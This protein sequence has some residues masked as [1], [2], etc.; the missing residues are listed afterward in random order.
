M[1]KRS[2]YHVQVFFI[3]LHKMPKIPSLANKKARKEFIHF[4]AARA[5]SRHNDVTNRS[6]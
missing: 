6:R 3:N 2:L 5:P 4:C 1:Q